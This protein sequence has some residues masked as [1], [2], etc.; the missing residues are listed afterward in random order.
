MKK[1]P[2][3]YMRQLN[4][5]D[6]AAERGRCAVSCSKK[7]MIKS[8]LHKLVGEILWLS[9]LRRYIWPRSPINFTA[10][11]LCFLC[12]C[13]EKT[14]NVP[15]SIAEIGCARGATTVFLNNYM[16]ARG[17]EKH[18]F[19]IDTFSGF[20]DGDIQYEVSIRGGGKDLFASAFAVNKKKWFDGTMK[21]NHIDRVKSIQA[22]VNQFDFST[23]GNLSF[24]LLD[25]DLYQPIKNSLK[26]LYDRL[27]VGG[28]IVVDDCDPDNPKWNG[29]YQAY[30]EFTKKN[31][32]P[33]RIVHGKLGMIEKIS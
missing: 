26:P 7:I 22:D 4:L 2:C 30:E 24:C 8:R 17:I 9:P 12:E 3:K 20:L 16:D 13:I 31:S 18:Y 28:I 10:P 6:A 19:A 23:L 33:L 29:S 32:L 21:L 14:M 25:V 5:E 11:Q 15:G 1:R 27:S